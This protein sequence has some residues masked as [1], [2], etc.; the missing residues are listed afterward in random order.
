MSI[1]S[2]GFSPKRPDTPCPRGTRNAI[3][4]NVLPS[5]PNN[6]TTQL[7][8][9]SPPRKPDVRMSRG[10]SP[11]MPNT[12]RP[13]SYVLRRFREFYPSPCLSVPLLQQSLERCSWVYRNST[14][15]TTVDPRV[16]QG[17]SAPIQRIRLSSGA[18]Y[19]RSGFQFLICIRNML[20]SGNLMEA[21]EL[22]N[23]VTREN[24]FKPRSRLSRQIR[25]EQKRLGE[26]FLKFANK[27]I[28]E[29]CSR[30]E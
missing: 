4:S 28:E 8:I 11:K 7:Q 19:L 13:S 3:S 9:P 16:S 25:E 27:M 12:S 15:S 2:R 20:E 18:S 1:P 29:K 10:F 23:R 17:T 30:N 6:P 21:Q 24:A 14:V 26:I 5:V 22:F